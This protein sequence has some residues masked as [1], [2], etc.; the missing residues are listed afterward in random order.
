[1]LDYA[2][3]MS[4]SVSGGHHM[5]HCIVC[6]ETE[7]HMHLTP[8]Q[9]LWSPDDGWQVGRL[10]AWCRPFAQKRQPEPDDYAYEK[11]GL[12]VSDEQDAIDAIYG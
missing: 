7:A 11:R 8:V 9:R 10:C 1:M 12:Y 2:Y 4:D 6:G 3:S 5:A